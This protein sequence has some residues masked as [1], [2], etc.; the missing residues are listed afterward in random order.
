M[1]ISSVTSI[2]H[3]THKA[4]LCEQISIKFHTENFISEFYFCT[5][6]ITAANVLRD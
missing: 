6:L 5:K 1:I 3:Y 2:C 4:E